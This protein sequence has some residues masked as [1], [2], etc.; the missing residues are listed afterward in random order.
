MN[1]NEEYTGVPSILAAPVTL[2]W[3][4]N[5]KQK[6]GKKPLEHHLI[7][8]FKKNNKIKFFFSEK[9]FSHSMYWAPICNLEWYRVGCD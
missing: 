1:I 5:E 4:Q 2:K 7:F 9:S 8:F 6:G 3:F